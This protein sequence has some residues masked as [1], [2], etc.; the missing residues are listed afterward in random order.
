[1][2]NLIFVGQIDLNYYFNT[3]FNSDTD[4]GVLTLVV[5][6]AKLAGS[7]TNS[8]HYTRCPDNLRLALLGD[9]YSLTE[10]VSR[11]IVCNTDQTIAEA[12][13]NSL[14]DC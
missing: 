5:D 14:Q 1:M 6:C 4:D 2:S 8:I 11:R 13:L 7:S 12:V 3:F 10:G 9:R